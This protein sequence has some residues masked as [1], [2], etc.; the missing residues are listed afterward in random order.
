MAES[1]EADSRLAEFRFG[2]ELLSKGD[3]RRDK[4]NDWLTHRIRPLFE[5]RGANSRRRDAEMVVLVDQGRKAGHTY[6][7]P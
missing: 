1:P 4:L 2:I 6:S 7:Q 5:Q 3:N